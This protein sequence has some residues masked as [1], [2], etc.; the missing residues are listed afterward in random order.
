MGENDDFP[1][2]W[3]AA[4]IFFALAGLLLTFIKVTAI[5]SNVHPSDRHVIIT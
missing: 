4:V 3:K 1:H 5:D 2:A